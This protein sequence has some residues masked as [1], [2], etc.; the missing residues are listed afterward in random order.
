MLLYERLYLLV[1]LGELLQVVLQEGDLLFLGHVAQSLLTVQL[2][3]LGTQRHTGLK[4]NSCLCQ[5][6]KDK[7]E[8][9]YLLHPRGEVL[10]EEFTQVVQSLQLFSL[11]QQGGNI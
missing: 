5:T 4:L 7:E 9:T 8:G 1:D 6:G 2:C 3:T 11:R 10:D